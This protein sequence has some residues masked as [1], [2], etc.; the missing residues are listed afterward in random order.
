MRE[1]RRSS[2]ISS[3]L[4]GGGMVILMMEVIIDG[5][6]GTGIFGLNTGDV[7]YGIVGM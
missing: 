7:D 3:A 1:K 2:S 4:V 5:R 6:G